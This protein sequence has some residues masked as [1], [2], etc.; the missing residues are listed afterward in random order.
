MP[1][2][3]GTAEYPENILEEIGKTTRFYK[4]DAMSIAKEFG[5]PL[6]QRCDSRYGCAPYGPKG[7]DWHSVIESTVKYAVNR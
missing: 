1:V 4:A 6:L 7:E 5:N 3:I 2:I